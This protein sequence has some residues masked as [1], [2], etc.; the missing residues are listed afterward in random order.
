[1]G[2]YYTAIS[3]DGKSISFYFRMNMFLLIQTDFDPF[4]DKHFWENE[5]IM[6]EDIRSLDA[7]NRYDDH[8]GY[9]IYLLEKDFNA[10]RL[11]VHITKKF[12]NYKNK[13]S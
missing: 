12:T 7:L 5:M 8:T 2:K 1:M 3:K 4:V 10:E 6:S 11:S 13:Q 9:V